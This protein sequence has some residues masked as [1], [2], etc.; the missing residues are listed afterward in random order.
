MT[1]T[2]D[3]KALAEN[4]TVV[5]AIDAASTATR[6]VDYAALF[7]PLI[8]I[9]A[10]SITGST[11]FVIRIID[12]DLA[13]GSETIKLIGVING[14]M[15]DEAEITL[16]DQAP[17]TPDPVD[18]VDPVDPGALAF[19][20][21]TMIPN[22]AYTS[23]T[24]ITPLVL[25]EASGG[26]APLTYSISVL[27]TGLVFD[28][29]TRTISGT[30]ATVESAVTVVAIYTVIDSAGSDRRV[31]FLYYGQPRNRFWFW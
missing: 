3:G 23:G 10:G 31:D 17:M 20:D 8:A 19:A 21:N 18:P 24:E 16:S 25:P 1:A 11:Q 28:A 7:N 9:P 5:V 22:Q 29:A 6:D 13:E 4:A 27:P 12:D 2:L 26:T 14:L 15:G 30:P